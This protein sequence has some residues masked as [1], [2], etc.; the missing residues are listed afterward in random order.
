MD[1]ISTCVASSIQGACDMIPI[2]FRCIRWRRLNPLNAKT[3]APNQ[4]PS[5]E[6]PSRGRSSHMPATAPT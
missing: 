3:I 2:T 1:V 6:R 4:A 5:L